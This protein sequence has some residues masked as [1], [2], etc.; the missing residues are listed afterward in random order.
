[1]TARD[2]EFDERVTRLESEVRIAR[3]DAAAARILAGG[4]DRDV[5]AMGA[6]LGQHG[7]MLE[8]H[9]A[10]LDVHKVLLDALRETQIEQGQRLFD[11]G[12]KIDSLERE[13][14]RGFGML[15][16]GQAQIVALLTRPDEPPPS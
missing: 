1:M 8:Q 14:R 16:T 2:D 10:K 12:Q 11:Q 4:A 7:A 13:M 3:Q 5:A 15:A 6:T 9:G